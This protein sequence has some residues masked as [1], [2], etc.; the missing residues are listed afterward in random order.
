MS[1]PT[2]LGGMPLSMAIVCVHFQ[3]IPINKYHFWLHIAF[4]RCWNVK[5]SQRGPW[6]RFG[7]KSSHSDRE[8]QHTHPKKTRKLHATTKQ[9]NAHTELGAEHELRQ[10][11]PMQT[12]WQKYSIE[13][14]CRYVCQQQQHRMARPEAS[15]AKMWCF[16]FGWR[17]FHVINCHAALK[18][19]LKCGFARFCSGRSVH[20]DAP[21]LYFGAV[22]MVELHSENHETR[23][24]LRLC[25]TA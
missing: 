5:R 23:V 14:M 3:F 20:F 19:R 24:L 2:T 25:W 8:R 4:I 10:L 21:L 7:L 15:G 12:K 11:W 17:I 16:V 9:L 22:E 18:K 13:P 1:E 6:K